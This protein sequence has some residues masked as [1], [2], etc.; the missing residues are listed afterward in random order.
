MIELAGALRARVR[1]DELE[2]YRTPDESYTHPD[3]ETGVDAATQ[4]TQRLI[5]RTRRRTWAL[6]ASIFATFLFLGWL[7]HLYSRA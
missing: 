1:G 4:E 6:N 2:T 7:V 3:D 5:R